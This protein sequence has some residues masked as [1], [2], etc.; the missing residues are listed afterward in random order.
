M[1]SDPDRE[2]G[3]ARRGGR[4][5]NWKDLTADI[6]RDPLDL[7]AI[8]NLNNSAVK[9]LEIISWKDLDHYCPGTLNIITVS[10]FPWIVLEELDTWLSLKDWLKNEIMKPCIC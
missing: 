1:C 4:E 5:E 7:R 2:N 3:R 8:L 10:R 6:G 9:T